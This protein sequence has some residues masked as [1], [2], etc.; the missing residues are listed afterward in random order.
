MPTVAW[1]ECRFVQAAQLLSTH[2]RPATPKTRNSTVHAPLHTG[3]HGPRVL[4]ILS[5][6]DFFFGK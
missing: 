6:A 1:R 3:L 4:F 2:P 5:V